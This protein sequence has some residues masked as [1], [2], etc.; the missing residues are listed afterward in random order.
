MADPFAAGQ[1][2]A[3]LLDDAFG[4]DFRQTALVYR[5]LGR[6]LVDASV[7]VVARDPRLFRKLLGLGLGAETLSTGHVLRFGLRRLE[8]S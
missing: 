3:V 1:R 5:I 8:D 7:R 4:A 6:Q 2:Y